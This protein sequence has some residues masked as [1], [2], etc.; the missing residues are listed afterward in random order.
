M[1]EKTLKKRARGNE[2]RKKRTNDKGSESQQIQAIGKGTPSGVST[3]KGGKCP[4]KVL[5]STVRIAWQKPKCPMTKGIEYRERVGM[6]DSEKG[7]WGYGPK[8]GG[9]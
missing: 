9:W 8:G 5:G 3:V 1:S 7:D 2:G 6:C 4:V